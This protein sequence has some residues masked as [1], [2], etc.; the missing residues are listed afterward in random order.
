[1]PDSAVTAGTVLRISNSEDTDTEPFYFCMGC[2][3]CLAVQIRSQVIQYNT[4]GRSQHFFL[5]SSYQKQQAFIQLIP[6]K[7][8]R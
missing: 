5:I 4:N 1:M 2:C 7:K 3:P 6:N 8:N